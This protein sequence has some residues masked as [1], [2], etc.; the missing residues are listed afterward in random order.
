MIGSIFTSTAGMTTFSEALDIIGNNVSNMNTPGYKGQ[1]MIFKDLFYQNQTG[2]NRDGSNTTIQTGSGSEIGSTV[3][4]T[5][6]GETR[7]TSSDTD[8]AID[9]NGFFLLRDGTETYYSRAGRFEFNEDQ[10]LV[11]TTT[12][13]KVA[14]ITSDGNLEDISIA[15]DRL[16]PAQATTYVNFEGTLNSNID[17]GNSYTIPTDT[18]NPDDAKVI[19]Y[20]S[21]GNKHEL[22]IKFTKVG[23]VS[24]STTQMV[25]LVEVSEDGNVLATEE[26]RYES[27]SPMEEYNS[28]LVELRPGT[29]ATADITLDLSDTRMLSAASSTIA[30]KDDDGIDGIPFGSL[31]SI[32]F[33]EEGKM[34]LQY[35]N[36]E[37]MAGQQIALALFND[38]HALKLKGDNLY[39]AI[40]GQNPIISNPGNQGLGNV[41]GGSIELSNVELS[42]EFSD[43]IIAQRG[44]QACSHLMNVSNEM[45]QQLFEL[46]GNR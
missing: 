31:V 28:V 34:T 8:I 16:N 40:A 3:I 12:G 22:E 1:E 46:G 27:G 13:Y 4:R 15:G 43:I 30:V 6:Q 36:G 38:V 37:E 21:I 26:I 14:G 24:G 18:P 35:S 11:D 41:I 33:D 44:Y 25:W 32:K 17:D 29:G 10:T 9:G 39:E 5:N 23:F 2:E 19:V 7:E 42:M 20:D 45:I